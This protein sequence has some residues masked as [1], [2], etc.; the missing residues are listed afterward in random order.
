MI[1]EKKFKHLKKVLN[2]KGNFISYP[3]YLNLSP[4]IEQLFTSFCVVF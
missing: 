2:E 3:F 1:I 4:Q